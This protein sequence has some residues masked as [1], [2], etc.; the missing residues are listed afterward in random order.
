M[1]STTSGPEGL[2]VAQDFE[3]AES[4]YLDELADL[5]D[6]RSIAISAP[7]LMTCGQSEPSQGS[8]TS[9][10]LSSTFTNIPLTVSTYGSKAATLMSQ[11]SSSSTSILNTTLTRPAS[12]SQSS[13]LAAATTAVRVSNTTGLHA[14]EQHTPLSSHYTASPQLLQLQQTQATGIISSVGVNQSN[15]QRLVTVQPTN[16]TSSQENLQHMKPVSITASSNSAVSQGNSKVINGGGISGVSTSPT[17]PDN[18]QRPQTQQQQNINEQ[19]QQQVCVKKECFL[20]VV[21]IWLIRIHN[22]EYR[23]RK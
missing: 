2:S 1:C 14:V 10:S 11:S 18:M 21:F 20:I 16:S 8:K 5:L 6:E 9:T 22:K 23:I 13:S 4:V 7:S 17:G 12:L 15:G 19:R 3:N